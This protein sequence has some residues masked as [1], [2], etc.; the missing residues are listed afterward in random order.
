MIQPSNAGFHFTR[1]SV[2]RNLRSS[3]GAED[4]GLLHVAHDAYTT[5]LGLQPNHAEA[6][7]EFA[8]LSDEMHREGIRKASARAAVQALWHSALELQP[9]SAVAWQKW[10]DALIR[11]DADSHT[12]LDEAALRYSAALRL[13][14][15]SHVAHALGIQQHLRGRWKAAAAAY[16]TALQLSPRDAKAALAL[17]SMQV[18]REPR[19]LP[20]F[21]TVLHRYSSSLA[22]SAPPPPPSTTDAGAA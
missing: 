21:P 18:R 22:A 6:A 4:A 2:L 12:R 9:A 19:C 14:P 11:E 1:G 17:G 7:L 8:A 3:S 20:P 13:L 10:G 16:R 5:A 15:S